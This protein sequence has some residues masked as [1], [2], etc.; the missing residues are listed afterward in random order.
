MVVGFLEA[1]LIGWGYGAN[2]FRKELNQASGSNITHLF[3]VVVK[4][5]L[6]LVLVILVGRQI[7][8]EFE[9]N[10]G[11]YALEYLLLY[12][13]AIL[14]LIGVLAACLAK[15]SKEHHP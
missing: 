4:F 1:I 5:F 9:S 8:K 3:P 2:R 15:A 7:T 13:L 10:Y 11:H 12:G 14:I 6:P